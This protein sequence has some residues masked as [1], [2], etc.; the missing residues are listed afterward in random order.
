M[1]SIRF[2]Q[3]LRYNRICSDPQDRASK[4]RDLQKAFLVLQYLPCMTKEQI[5]K[6]RGIPRDNLLQDQSKGPND[7][8][9]LVVTY[10]PQVRPLTYILNDL[11]PILDK[12]MPLSKILCG[13][14]ILAYR[15]IPQNDFMA[16]GDKLVT[17]HT[18]QSL[19]SDGDMQGQTI[20]LA[21][22]EE[23]GLLVNGVC[24]IQMK[25]QDKL[26]KEVPLP[27]ADKDI[28]I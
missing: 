17:C 9:P 24:S 4:L 11:Q 13:R 3:A 7:R 5:N 1:K 2:S 12:N 22:L 6:A 8:I 26:P 20:I 15:Q 16:H 19:H 14:P 23:S 28:V 18:F 27:G 21:T 10:S 25:G